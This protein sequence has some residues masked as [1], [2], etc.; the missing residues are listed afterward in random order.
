MSVILL[1]I[2]KYVDIAYE[3][4]KQ[5][6][7]YYSSVNLYSTTFGTGWKLESKERKRIRVLLSVQI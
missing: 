1:A 3:D 2:S 6:N 5:S 4:S 7:T